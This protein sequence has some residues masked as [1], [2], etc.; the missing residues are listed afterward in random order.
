VP[1]MIFLWKCLLLLSSNVF[2]ITQVGTN[3]FTSHS[4]IPN[5]FRSHRHQGIEFQTLTSKPDSTVPLSSSQTPNPV[6][7]FSE[8]RKATLFQ[9]LLRDLEVE[10]VPLLDCDA[11]Q[12]STLQA[13]LWT[14]MAELSESDDVG[15]V[16]LVFES[17]PMGTLKSL[18]DNFHAFKNQE[19]FMNHLPE[20][21]RFS[22][23]L[24]GKGIGPAIVIQTSNRTETEKAEYNNMKKNSAVPNE[25][26]WT[27]AM[28]TFVARLTTGLGLKLFASA[29]TEVLISPAYRIVGSLD[30]CDVLSGFWNSVCELQVARDDGQMNSV[31]MSFPP[32]LIDSKEKSHARF[33]AET[34][35][36]SRMFLSFEVNDSFEV[37]YMHPLYDCDEIVSPDS[38]FFGHLLPTTELKSMMQKNGLKEL[39]KEELTLQN[40]QRRSPL[41]T[42]V[43]QRIPVRYFT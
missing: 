21:N 30:V 16:C 8:E 10:G 36:I 42:V 32:S 26:R 23:D 14:I 40:F 13:A 6:D 4:T 41:P 22:M 18:V 34:N 20:L 7:E 27:A 5:Q 39:S 3:A 37:L 2:V 38:L 17:I 1:T 19:D 11:T 35:L 28:K 12:S 33:V 43:V 24:V 31:I 15:K 9:F 29:P 25:I